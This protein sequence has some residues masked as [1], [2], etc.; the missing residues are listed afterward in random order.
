MVLMDQAVLLELMA[1]L[2]LVD[3]V[4]LQELMELQE[5]MVLMDQAVLLELMVLL[6]PMA[7]QVLTEQM[8]QVV[9]QVTKVH[10]QAKKAIQTAY[11]LA[12]LLINYI[13][14]LMEVFG[15]G[16]VQIGKTYHL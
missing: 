2:V 7:L 11:I 8:D 1:L 14:H 10:Y 13:L 16:E 3:Q 9:L 15:S 6:E 5:L 4:V 12:L